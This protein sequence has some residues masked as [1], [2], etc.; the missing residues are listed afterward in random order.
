MTKIIWMPRFAPIYDHLLVIFPLV[1]GK[2]KKYKYAS[3][4]QITYKGKKNSFNEKSFKHKTSPQNNT[5][6]VQFQFC[7]M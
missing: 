5:K 7:N 6:C 2:E 1:Q 4:K 3:K